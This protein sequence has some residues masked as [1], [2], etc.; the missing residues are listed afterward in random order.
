N[1]GG[2]NGGITN[3]SPIVI[4]TAVKPTPSI[5]KEQDTIDFINKENVRRKITGRHDPA[6]IHR[7]RA[8]VD[9][10]CS[11]AVFDMLSFRYGTDFFGDGK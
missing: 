5:A 6:V 9:A 7:A 8:V 4:N 10:L 1:N 2:C 11:F 3:G